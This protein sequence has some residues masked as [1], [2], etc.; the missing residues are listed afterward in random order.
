MSLDELER[1]IAEICSKYVEKYKTEQK[2]IVVP[3]FKQIYME[4]V[5]TP[6]EQELTVGSLLRRLH[7][8]DPSKPA[9][10]PFLPFPI[11][12]RLAIHLTKTLEIQ[13]NCDHY[14]YW[15]WSAEVFRALERDVA[16]LQELDRNTI[17][18]LYLIFHLW[19][20]KIGYTPRTP[21]AII[22]NRI[23]SEAVSWHV[24]E[25]IT[26]KF[27]LGIP[28]AVAFFECLI[29]MTIEKFG[30]PEAVN[31]LN[32]L[33]K[34]ATLG[35]ILKIFRKKV[36]PILQKDFRED[37]EKL[38]E[39]V[40]I[41]WGGGNKSWIDILLDWRNKFMHGGKTWAPKAFGVYTNYICLILWHMVPQDIYDKKKEDIQDKIKMELE[42]GMRHPWGFYPP[43]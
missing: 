20:S 1:L 40:E 19:M 30:P 3:D 14:E 41:I 36:L 27:I 24:Q 29:K 15:S 35:K 8:E 6:I 31:E 22:L 10:I 34:R 2:Y 4:D 25:V 5:G 18:I 7:T 39:L 11:L 38:N 33:G 21:E 16:F 12:R 23:L 37:F 43:F 9:A 26:S 32:S 28:L 17:E 42:M 13:V